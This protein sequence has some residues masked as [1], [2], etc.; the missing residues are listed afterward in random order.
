MLLLSFVFIN[1][2]NQKAAN[3]TIRE[4]QE[5]LIQQE[6]LASLGQMSAGIA[7]EIRNPLNFITNFSSVS[8]D[9]LDELKHAP[10]AEEQ[11]DVI[12]LIEN[13]LAKIEQH[14]RRAENIVKNMID[15]S[16]NRAGEYELISLNQLCRQTA[17]MAYQ[18]WMALT[19]G[20]RCEI[21][22]DFQTLPRVKL[23][24]KEISRVM[25]NLFNNSFYAVYEKQKADPAF[26]PL[27]SIHS[28]VKDKTVVV[29]IVDN[30]YGIPAAVKNKIFQ[31]FF[32]TKP[33]GEGTGLGLSISYEIIQAHGGRLSFESR[34]GQGACFTIELPVG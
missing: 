29:N 21:R 30:G 26:Q 18:N 4:K 34:E 10:N 7:H 25:L 16:Q 1:Y 19:P 20:F 28:L 5:Q 27:V 22:H 24:G 31:P 15:H 6:K 2:R 13:N 23:I 14:G 8:I 12:M 33:P 17:N 3:R 32:T 11:N 9:L